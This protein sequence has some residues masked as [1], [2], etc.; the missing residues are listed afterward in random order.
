VLK[1][2]GLLLTRHAQ[3]VP[4]SLPEGVVHVPSA[5]F[6][7]LLPR[8]A[9]IVHHGGIGTMAQGFAAGIPQLVMPMSH[10]QPDNAARAC[11]L[12]VAEELPP[13]RFRGNLV[14][15]ALRRLLDSP[16][17]ARNCDAVAA[18]LRDARPI[19]RTCELIESLARPRDAAA[20]SG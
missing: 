2:R 20:R 17:V 8:C 10:D 1:R 6:S 13:K 18:R 7:E 15:E 19:E 14:A 9:A 12:G 16:E 4:A 3:H 11:G 5:P